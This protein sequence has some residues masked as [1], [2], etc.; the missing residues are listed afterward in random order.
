M[1]SLLKYFQNFPARL[2][3]KFL[4]DEI[5]E[6]GE[7]LYQ[8]QEPKARDRLCVYMRDL[9]CERNRVLHELHQAKASTAPV[10]LPELTAV[11]ALITLIALSVIK[12]AVMLP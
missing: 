4:D 5:Q 12:I 2:H 1:N 11:G 10:N 8:C 9:L 6:Q 7:I 3:L